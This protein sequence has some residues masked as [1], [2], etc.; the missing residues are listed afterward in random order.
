MDI[1]TG[2]LLVLAATAAAPVDDP[3]T[4]LADRVAPKL[5]DRLDLLP[6][7]AV[8]IDGWLGARIDANVARRLAVVDT[9]PLLAG[10][11]KRPG[12]HP[13]IGE[14]VGKWL[15]AATL[16]WA[17]TGDDALRR[18][19]DRVAADLI[20]CQEPDG[21][22][23]TYLP[24]QRFGLYRDADW[25]VW[26]HKYNLIGLLTY[27]QYTGDPSALDCCRKMADLLIATFPAKQSILAAGTH[28]GMA[29][30]S[31]LEPIVLLYRA[32][33]DERYLTF[34]RYIVASW[35]EP[36]GPKVASTL[37][38]LKRV[39]RTANGKA[40]EML[41]NLVGLLRVGQDYWR[42]Q[43]LEA[44][45]HAWEDIVANRLYLTGSASYGELFHDDHD[46]PN[47]AAAHVGETCVTTTWI[48]LNLQLLRLTGEAR[49]ADEL[50][51]SL[52]NH[53][54]AA[55]HPRGEDW[56]YYTALEGRKPYD[57]SITC[58]HSS[59]PRGMAL[60]PQAVYL[61]SGDSIAIANIFDPSRATIRLRDAVVRIRLSSCLFP[62]VGDTVIEVDPDRPVEFSLQL[63][64]PEWMRTVEVK[65]QA[66]RVAGRPQ[67]GWVEIPSRRWA[68]PDALTIRFGLE[69]R[70]IVGDHGN[71]GRAALGWGPFVLAYDSTRNPEGPAPVRIGLT[72]AR[73]PVQAEPLFSLVMPR[74]T[75]P[76]VG[77][78][79]EEPRPATFVTFADAGRDGGTYRVWLRA[80]G[81]P[82]FA[83]DS[84]LLD[85]TE[86][87]SRP[88]NVA[89]S[90]V[91]GD[92]GSFVVTFDAQPADEDWFAATLEKPT[93]IRR[94]TFAHGKNFHDGGWFD[95]SA[96]KPRVQVK[97]TPEGPWQTIGTLDDYPAT[98]ATENR[99]L[100]EGQAFTLRLAEPVTA[101]A[102]RVIGKPSSGD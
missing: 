25:D 60:A 54:A 52:Y 99:G 53:L 34:A 44:T 14:H 43:W 75:A 49:Y 2:L 9:E 70:L 62:D 82:E 89:G 6:P 67:G 39:D 45:I 19:L 84:L 37:L 51:R 20:A 3:I 79:G 96:G 87:R 22:L 91:D 101:S 80:P 83:G 10:Y 40:Y 102:V 88:G 28:V 4:P 58:C 68:G 77:R 86:S 48:Q 74:F 76:I 64:V 94:V 24:G 47:Q 1:A 97:R 71:A 38:A 17:Y 27:Y 95:A 72:E 66:I 36:N 35:E 41:S 30:T 32:T 65:G 59:G 90:I 46:L 50:E 18:K 73:P 63:R 13:W 61:K 57:A 15:H 29:A 33:G 7:S 26:S 92:P 16:A 31:V 93:A 98:K 42:A 55:Q 85:A 69:G 78:A 100:K 8:H 56:C 12:S 11:R 5:I 21:Y 23:G 81:V